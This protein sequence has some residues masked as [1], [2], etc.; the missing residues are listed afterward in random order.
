MVVLGIYVMTHGFLDSAHLDE[1][2][3]IQH[4]N[5]RPQHYRDLEWSDKFYVLVVRVVTKIPI[6]KTHNRL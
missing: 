5:R 1:F 3:D 2:N 6:G 4:D